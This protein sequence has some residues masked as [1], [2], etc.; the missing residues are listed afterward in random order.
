MKRD[1]KSARGFSLLELSLVLLIIGLLFGSMM[2]GLSAYRQI[3][4]NAEADRQ[5]AVAYEALLGFAMRNGRL[6]CPAAPEARGN[7]SPEGGGN[8]THPWNGLL[9]AATLGL[10]G[11]D[12]QGYAL[13][14]WGN[15]LGYA[16][17]TFTNTA[18]GNAPC[19]SSENAIRQSWN[20]EAPPAPDLR[21]CSTAK[22]KSGLGDKAECASGSALTKDAVAI[23]YSPGRNGMRQPASSDEMANRDNDRLFVWHTETLPPDEFD[24]RLTWLS[25]AIYYSRLMMAGRLPRRK[26]LHKK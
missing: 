23:V 24:D 19:L 26:K 10:Q 14:P 4:E 25:S 16:I 7:E 5:L 1:D 2:P 13:D 20:G 9:P 12:A 11:V 22:D 21:V 17:S 3:A 6:P 15:R 18:C 8:C